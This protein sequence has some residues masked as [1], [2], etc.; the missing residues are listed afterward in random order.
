MAENESLKYGEY[1]RGHDRQDNI[2]WNQA[3]TGTQRKEANTKRMLSKGLGDKAWKRNRRITSVMKSV[4]PVE[5]LQHNT[6]DMSQKGILNDKHPTQ[7]QADTANQAL[8]L[9]AKLATSRFEEYEKESRVPLAQI[10][11]PAN[12]PKKTGLRCASIINAHR[13][14]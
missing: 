3:T 13:T 14:L 2:Y 10:T 9:V 5:R 4:S 12:D 11:D 6:E 8:S 7:K 1:R